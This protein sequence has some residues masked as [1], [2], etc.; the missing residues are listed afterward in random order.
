MSSSKIWIRF[1]EIENKLPEGL[2]DLIEEELAEIDLGRE[3]VER[4]ER[5]LATML[6]QL[7]AVIR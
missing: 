3:G 6:E 2:A 5:K 7:A 1:A 4:R